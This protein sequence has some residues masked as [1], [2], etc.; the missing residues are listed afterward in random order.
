[1]S[2]ARP[3][4]I[5]ARRKTS[6]SRG[7]ARPQFL[8]PR[9]IEGALREVAGAAEK[10]GTR[11]ALAGGCALQLYGS[12]RFT[13]GI[14]LLVDGTIP[15]IRSQGALSFGGVQGVTGDGVPVDLIDRADQ[16]AALYA[17]ALRDASRIPDVPAPV[18]TLPYLAAMKM[19][20][21]R[22]KDEQDL[23]FIL[24][25]SGAKLADVL[26]VVRRHLGLYAVDELKS[27]K[28]IAQWRRRQ[29]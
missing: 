3:K 26:R 28:K 12:P 19:V 13:Q 2:K 14:D 17:D 8:D 4:Q 10:A 11:I 22:G 21:G 25:D 20:A 7:G 5:D 29:S 9:R 18:V 27:F 6:T 24:L 1:M 16:Y 15:G 23:E